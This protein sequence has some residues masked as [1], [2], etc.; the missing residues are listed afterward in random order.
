M[1]DQ[2]KYH[3]DSKRHPTNKGIAPNNYRPITCL[4]MMCKILRAKNWEEI[5]YSLISHRLF[6]EEEKRCHKWTRETDNLLYT[7]HTSSWRAKRDEKCRYVM[8][9][10]DKETRYGPS[11]LDNMLS[12]N[13]QGSRQIHNGY[14]GKYEKLEYRTGNRRKKLAELKI[15]RGIFQGDAQSPLLFV[16]EMMPFKHILRKCIG[17]YKLTT[18][19]ERIKHLMYMDN[20]RLFSKTADP[21]TGSE[22]VHLVYRDEIWHRKMCHANYEKRKTVNNGRNRTI[23]SRKNQKALRKGN[24]EYLGI[25]EA[26]IMKQE[27]IK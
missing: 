15:L 16:I 5:F 9:W 2:R 22:N 11:K 13:I 12:Q 19:Q 8:D 1:D 18:S 20:I 23:K 21:N 7:D 4:P 17:G 6:P 25:L 10:L 26:D 24:W 14:Q 3:S 27:E